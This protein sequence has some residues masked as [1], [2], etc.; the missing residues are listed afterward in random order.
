MS[1]D[2]QRI[3]NQFKLVMKHHRWLRSVAYSFARTEFER[4][5]LVQET[6][7]KVWEAIKAD[8]IRGGETDPKQMRSL[9]FLVCRNVAINWARHKEVV[10]IEYVSEEELSGIEELWGDV[11][12]ELIVEDEVERFFRGLEELP[13]KTRQVIVLKRVMGYQQREIAEQL[14]LSE[15]T[16]EDHIKRAGRLL[17]GALGEGLAAWGSGRQQRSVADMVRA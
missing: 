16:I 12:A 5:D 11:V 6:L 7:L 8:T 3:T 10:E 4:D 14:G 2:S 15:N 9:L 13:T 1:R 17:T